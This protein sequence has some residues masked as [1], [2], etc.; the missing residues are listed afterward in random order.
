MCLGP[1]RHF[2]GIIMEFKIWGMHR[3][4]ITDHKIHNIMA[5]ANQA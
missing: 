2:S 5:D 4:I 1:F 3:V